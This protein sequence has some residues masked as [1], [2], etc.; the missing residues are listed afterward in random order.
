MAFSS[1]QSINIRPE[2][3]ILSILKNVNYKAWFA[4]A[5]FVDN[6]IQSSIAT[7]NA[8][9]QV[10]GENYQLKVSIE[11]D[12]TEGQ[13]KITIRDNAGGINSDTF[14][15]A[16]RPAAIPVVR[17]GLSEFGMGMKSAACWFA[18]YW[19]V[20]TTAIGEPIER[21]V[22]FDVERIVADQTEDLSIKEIPVLAQ[23]HYTEVVLTRLNQIPQTSTIAKIK[24]HLAS[25]Y[26]VYLR[27]G[28]L[29][30]TYNGQPITYEFPSV[31]EAPH[32]ETGSPTRWIKEI[33]LEI[34]PGMKI[35]GFAGL[36]SKG[37]TSNAGFALLR[38]K[39]VIF[40]SD[41]EPYR[42]YE[43]FGKPNSFMYQR[44]FG[45]LNLEGFEVSHTKDGIQWNQYED[46][47]LRTLKNLLNED[48]LPLLRQSKESYKPKQPQN[49]SNQ[50]SQQDIS[51]SSLPKTTSI[52][53]S[54]SHSHQ[55]STN[56]QTSPSTVFSGIGISSQG[57]SPRSP[58]TSSIPSVAK[59]SSQPREYEKKTFQISLNGQIWTVRVELNKDSGIGDWWSILGVGKFETDIRISL[60]HPFM[61]QF[62]FEDDSSLEP[63]I[64]LIA[65]MAVAEMI[66]QQSGIQKA[67]VFRM[68]I[69]EALRNGF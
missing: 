50:Q 46:T 23:E 39:R 5:E 10:A 40:G 67:G 19:T 31:L 54:T 21:I 25:M 51:A 56:T 60:A 37:S 58:S 68:Y 41:D 36:L 57:A 44:L 66:A 32:Y 59:P 11:I 22:T 47:V 13:E 35:K 8:L 33:E 16:F 1:I 29:N 24:R 43:I 53:N 38:R 15:R 62:Y 6:A 69:N 34:K 9:V 20:R 52:V 18:D 45:E 2:V 63:I 48:P 4:I 55:P 27:E 61:T 14:P 26:R 42:P 30:L 64:R 65:T 49:Q 17:T 28:L 3:N 12:V 7:R